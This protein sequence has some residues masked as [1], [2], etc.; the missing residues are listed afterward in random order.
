MTHSSNTIPM[1]LNM[2]GPGEYEVQGAVGRICLAQSEKR[3][4]PAFSMGAKTKKPYWPTYHIDFL[5]RDSPGMNIYNPKIHS[6]TQ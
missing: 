2:T 1:H 4:Y 3:N 5:G 6:T